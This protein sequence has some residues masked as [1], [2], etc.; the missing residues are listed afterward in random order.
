MRVYSNEKEAFT[1]LKLRFPRGADVG[2]EFS[3]VTFAANGSEKKRATFTVVAEQVWSA[4]GNSRVMGLVWSSRCDACQ[5]PFYQLSPTH[6]DAL[7]QHCSFCASEKYETHNHVDP[8]I[9]SKHR[10]GRSVNV[11]RRGRVEQV[12]VDAARSFAPISS[13]H[14][15]E[16]IERAI[17]MMTP[18]PAPMRDTRRQA[19]VRSIASLNR[20]KDGPLLVSGRKVVFC[21]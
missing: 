5:S 17:G 18:P 6:P 21:E 15:E 3:Y 10:Q 9:F 7:K 20:E 1:D 11:K 14:I 16:L 4:G 8:V 12:V 19:V 13:V 2:T